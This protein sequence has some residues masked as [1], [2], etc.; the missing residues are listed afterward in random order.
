MAEQFEILS[1][2]RFYLELKLDG[3]KNPIDAY[4]ME[5]QGFKRSQ[6]VIEICEVTPQKWGKSGA[7]KGKVVRTK[8]PGNQKSENITLKRGLT[9]STTMWKW[10]QAV[11]EGEWGKQRKDGDLTIYDQGAV[12]RAR[13]R[14]QGA[15][16]V[17]YKIGDVKAGNNEFEVE[18]VELAVDHFIRVK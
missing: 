13:F 18:E 2:A 8:L 3:S 9:V 11:E 17:G 6:E 7:K 14:F 16:P 15:W 1:S 4:F 12:E 10:F 5:C